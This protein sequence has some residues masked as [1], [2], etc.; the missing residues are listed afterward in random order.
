ML[1]RRHLRTRVMQAIYSL[2]HSA[3]NASTVESEMFNGID[4]SYDLYLTLLQLFIELA[5]EE[6]LYYTDAPAKF[7]K[8]EQPVKFRLS[9]NVFL[10]WLNNDTA[11]KELV[12]HRKISW[13]NDTDIIKKVFYQIRNTEGYKNYVTS[14]NHDET[15]DI[16]FLVW[17]YKSVIISSEVLQN[18]MEEKNIWWAESLDL[19]NSMVLKTIKVSHPARKGTFNLMPI[20]REEEED[21][22]FLRKL[23]HGT[24]ENNDYFINL[25]AD[26]TKNWDVDRIA[27][28]DVILLK[29][30]LNEILNFPSI[31]V[32]VSINEY[33]DLSKEYST[34]KS[35]VFINGVLD[36][37]VNDL[38]SAGTIA[39]TGRGLVE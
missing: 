38:I 28:L 2:H 8:K 31:P 30:A 7:I 23:F 32:K 29:M 11:F 10:T 9:E 1:S 21:K 5:H 36:S 35:K 25:I 24:I 12:D 27:Q 17:L 3:R 4:R 34:P 39:K 6:D 26:K 14:S 33:I 18:L 22:E 13:Q 37:I 16:D 20:L 15:T 19:I